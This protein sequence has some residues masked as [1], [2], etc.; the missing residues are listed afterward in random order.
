MPV[1]TDLKKFLL[2][3]S[4]GL[5]L[6]L[7]FS[8]E[9][10]ESQKTGM[11]A[12]IGPDTITIIDLDQTVSAIPLPHRLEYKSEQAL[13]DLVQSMID[14]KLMAKQSVKLGLDRETDVKAQLET[15]KGKPASQADQL[16]PL[17]VE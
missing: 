15:M 16:E 13:N 3:L 9:T 6:F 12:T 14:W 7:T 17:S 8:C 5:F 2:L 11:I 1:T 10:G 4:I